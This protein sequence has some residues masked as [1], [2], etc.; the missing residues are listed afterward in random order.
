MP[1]TTSRSGFGTCFISGSRVKIVRV[2]L[3][4]RVF[5]KSSLPSSRLLRSQAQRRKG[6]LR[7]RKNRELGRHD[8]CTDGKCGERTDFGQ[9][10][11]GV[12]LQSTRAVDTLVILMGLSKIRA[13]M[14]QLQA[15]G[16][17]SE[18]PAALIQSGTLPTQKIVVGTVASLAE[19][20]YRGGFASPSVIVVN[21]AVNFADNPAQFLHPSPSD[22]LPVVADQRWA[23]S[24]KP[25]QKVSMSDETSGMAPSGFADH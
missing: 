10:A 18:R 8:E 17:P 2:S 20:S 16:C 11:F 12:E 24:A 13:I 9:G 5:S 23:K 22:K 15:E 1:R 21:E 3:D 19:L 4:R 6:Y 25:A 14:N 7:G